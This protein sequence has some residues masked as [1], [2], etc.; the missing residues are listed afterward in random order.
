MATLLGMALG[1]WMSG[2]IFDFTGSYQAAFLNGARLEPGER[3]DHELAAAAHARPAVA[4]ERV[5]SY[6]MR[7]RPRMPYRIAVARGINQQ[8][9]FVL[10]QLLNMR[11]RRPG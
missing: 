11:S 9:Y 7:R 4:R 2:A 10:W 8:P 5:N 6:R 3:R 1:G